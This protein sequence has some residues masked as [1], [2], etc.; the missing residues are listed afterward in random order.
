MYS[1]SISIYLILS[2]HTVPMC[3]SMYSF[4]LFNPSDLWNLSS[5]IRVQYS[6][7]SQVAI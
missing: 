1:Y 6:L 2:L 3:N 5:S 4:V 7:F